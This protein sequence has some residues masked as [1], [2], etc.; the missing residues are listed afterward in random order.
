ML[1]FIHF[2]GDHGGL[3]REDSLKMQRASARGRW[4]IDPDQGA[5]VLGRKPMQEE[6][7]LSEIIGAIYDAALDPTIWPAAIGNVVAFCKMPAGCIIARDVVKQTSRIEFAIGLPAA[8]QGLN[9]HRYLRL[10]GADAVLSSANKGDVI[11]L[12]DL[13]STARFDRARFSRDWLKRHGWSDVLLIPIYAG[14]SHR[15]IFAMARSVGQRIDDCNRIQLLSP[16]LQQALII[17]RPLIATQTQVASFEAALDRL[18][19]GIFLLSPKGTVVQANSSGNAMLKEGHILQMLGGELRFRDMATDQLIRGTLAAAGEGH[20][21]DAPSPVVSEM[22]L[23]NGTQY[24]ARLLPLRGDLPQGKGADLTAV[25]ALF[26]Y[27][28]ELETA[29]PLKLIAETYNLT[30]AEMRTFLAVVQV[31][32]VPEAAETLGVAKNT[33]RVLLQR[34]YN[35]TGANRQAELAKLLASFSTPLA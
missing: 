3:I 29:S 14:G 15:L 33:I 35:K 6:A 4:C 18:K 10:P 28:A 23:P 17:S 22:M 26:V 5:Q 27:Q 12:S 19:P 24:V 11:C 21:S 20:S 31:G 16:H 2:D 25:L 30:S 1:V 32:G 9:I 7:E 13:M 34:V 8:W